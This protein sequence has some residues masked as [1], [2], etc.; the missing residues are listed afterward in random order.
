M[1]LNRKNFNFFLCNKFIMW[2]KFLKEG[3]MGMFIK[4]YVYALY[5]RSI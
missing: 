1:L 3:V 4:F 2:I 5:F